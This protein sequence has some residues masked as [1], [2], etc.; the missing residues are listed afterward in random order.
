[1][2]IYIYKVKNTLIVI[3]IPRNRKCYVL[4]QITCLEAVDELNILNFATF[5]G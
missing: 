3:K 4:H 2:Q 1:M 5:N